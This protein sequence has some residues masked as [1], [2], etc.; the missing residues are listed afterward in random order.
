MTPLLDVNILIY[1]HR[2]ELP[3]HA[4]AKA[5]LERL[6][7]GEELFGVPE[8]VF[9][10]LIRIVTAQRPFIPPTKT[11]TALDFCHAVMSSPRCLVVRPSQKHWSVFD[12]LCR[13]TN[14]RGNLVP[15]AYL[16]ALAIDQGFMFVTT[17]SDYSKFPELTWRELRDS[18]PRTNPR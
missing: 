8:L 3:R 10:A 17:D 15:D 9:S 6:R 7:H 14:A 2:D 16:A 4:E 12:R 11:A 1:A 5:Y 18:N 13:T